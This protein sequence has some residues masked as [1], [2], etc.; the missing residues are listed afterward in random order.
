MTKLAKKFL[1]SISLVLL[2]ITGL[3]V[4]LNNTLIGRYYTYQKKQQMNQIA[5][6][7]LRDGFPQEE[8]IEELEKEHHVIIVTV[9]QNDD[10]N[11]LNERLK[12]A[13]LDKGLGIAKY[14]LW[15]Q[16]Y[17]KAIQK[18]RFIRLYRQEKVNYDLAV[19][20]TSFN[21]SFIGI[22]SVIP[23]MEETIALIN[24]STILIVS[25]G[26]FCIIFICILLVKKITDPLKQM[27]EFAVRIARQDYGTISLHTRDELETVADSMNQMSD[28]IRETHELLELKNHQMEE[29][30]NNVSHELKTPISLIKAYASG[31]Q[32][33]MDDGTFLDTIVH[34]NNR[35]GELTEKLLFMSGMERKQ[36]RRTLVN[37]TELLD[38]ILL[39]QRMNLKKNQLTIH[40][41][42]APMA[43]I[44]AN[45]E[46]I[47]MMMENLITNAIKYSS[48]T[49]IWIRLEAVG[50]RYV[51]RVEN[52]TEAHNLDPQ[53]I[54]EPF[55]VG[56][57]SRNGDM[58]G[59][60]LGLA[61]VKAGAEAC[62]FI[63]GCSLTDT[64][65]NGT[66]QF[67]IEFC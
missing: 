53:Q 57:S 29:L 37:L 17:E 7:L 26:L 18:G 9:E 62:G 36:S 66:V 47:H 64:P 3:C 28:S 24:K 46:I 23:N 67:W 11:R 20:Y 42:A 38:H 60:G 55:Y 52:T 50:E 56:E 2:L 25:G 61:L 16:D 35:M 63:Y 27:T 14:W 6:Q 43:T 5:G 32:D 8:W 34:Q 30:L 49:E 12:Q 19:L 1:V 58:S 41:T 65:A 39:M 48:G 4:L 45:T 51:F 40:S 33:G 21:G 13:F 31:I 59:T 44:K 15:D 10:I 22:A 54:W